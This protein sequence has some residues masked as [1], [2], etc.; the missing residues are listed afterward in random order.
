MDTSKKTSDTREWSQDDETAALSRGTNV[1]IDTNF[2]KLRRGER[3]CEGKSWAWTRRCKT[4]GLRYVSNSV[5]SH[6]LPCST[7]PAMLLPLVGWPR[8]SPPLPS[9]PPRRITLWCPKCTGVKVPHTLF[10]ELPFNG[11]KAASSPADTMPTSNGVIPR[12][13]RNSAVSFLAF[14]YSNQNN[15]VLW[16]KVGRSTF[17]SCHFWI[18]SIVPEGVTCHLIALLDLLLIRRII[19]NDRDLELWRTNEYW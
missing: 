13:T 17:S 5:M 1:N 18:M 19:S 15:K 8:P 3:R 11:V 12:T 9:Q 6:P 14:N 7:P 10:A 2:C 4:Q 16:K